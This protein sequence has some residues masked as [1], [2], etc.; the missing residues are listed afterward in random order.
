MALYLLGS[1]VMGQLGMPE[2]FFSTNKPTEHPFFKDKE[3]V[4]IS[5]GK[6]HALIL[7]KNNFLYSYGVN[8]DC[9]LGR[10]GNQFAPELIDFPHEIVDI[11]AGASYSAILT[12]KGHVYGCGTFK[13]SSGVFG[14][15]PKS[16][17][18]KSFKR[19]QN[20]KGI[21]KIFPGQ[22]HIILLDKKGNIWTFGANE[23]HQLGRRH[24]ERHTERC[25]EASQ[26]SSKVR[27]SD[28][29]QFIKAAAG[30]CHSMAI[31][32]KNE[33]Y[34]WG[35]NFNGQLGDGTGEGSEMR[36]K[37]LLEN[38]KQV[39]CGSSHSLF[40]CKKDK[41]LNIGNYDLYGTGDN[42]LSQLGIKGEKMYKEPIF[43][44]SGI[45]QVEAGCDF[46]IVR[47]GNKLFSFGSNL[48][49]ELGFDE[50]ECDEIFTPREIDFDFGKI[51]DFCCGTDF[52]MIQTK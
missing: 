27:S 14:F 33:C 17:F 8:D 31:N 38:V 29:N 40:L 23:A 44:M 13:S 5:A 42:T 34:G 51:E 43:I 4:K 41:D 9:A 28:L 1:N 7:C 16:K 10:E 2:E 30:G 6:L 12:A 19:I 39:A 3:I 50:I 24:R 36:R 45:D 18:Q 26:I 20:L 25:L 37:V 52:T 21:S 11:C 49:G 35:G 22:N 48:N 46:T 15:D 32:V 47:K